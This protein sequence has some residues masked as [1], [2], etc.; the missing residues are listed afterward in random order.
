MFTH[1]SHLYDKIYSFKDYEKES[2]DI[3]ESICEKRLDCRTILDVGCGTAEHH[4]Y[5]GQHFGVDGIDLNKEFVAIAERKNPGG[6]YLVANM[7]DFDLGTQYDVVLC[8][9]S[10]IAYLA[11]P[12]EMLSA[13]KC[14]HRHLKPNGLA[15]IEP[16]FTKENL[17]EQKVHM[18][19]H[20]DE[21]M[22]ICRMNRSAVSGNYSIINFHY[23]V[24]TLKEGVRHFE[25]E[26]K[27]RLTSKDEYFDLF[28]KAG[29]EVTFEEE[30]LSGRGIYYAVRK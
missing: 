28:R 21:D 12:E 7:I 11:T 15:I 26:H 16:W 22:K 9:F 8:L 18:L 24:G 3:I 4:K 25:E 5:L 14:F 6:R 19:T 23:L 13:L 20:E 30:G 29:F 27:L 1:T 17:P 10:S 2:E